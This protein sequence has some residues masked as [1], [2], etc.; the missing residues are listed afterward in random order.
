MG[1]TDPTKIQEWATLR[2]EFSGAPCADNPMTEGQLMNCLAQGHRGKLG[3]V[4][5]MHRRAEVQWSRMRFENLRDV[6]GVGE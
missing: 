5:E 1:E 3:I 2:R 4:K 6:V